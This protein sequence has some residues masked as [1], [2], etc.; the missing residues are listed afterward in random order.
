MQEVV[1]SQDQLSLL[2]LIQQLMVVVTL[3]V[4]VHGSRLINMQMMNP[5]IQLNYNDFLDDSFRIHQ[6]VSIFDGYLNRTY[7]WTCSLL[8]QN[9]PI[10]LTLIL[11]RY[12]TCH[13]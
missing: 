8:D 1:V 3:L 12:L 10:N 5:L 11:K 6:Q 9:N 7:D 13:N 2:L 4:V